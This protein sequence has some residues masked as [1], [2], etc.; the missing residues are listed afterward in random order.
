[1]E[2]SNPEWYKHLDISFCF[3]NGSADR[4]K[5]TLHVKVENNKLVHQHS[6]LRFC[7]IF[8]FLLTCFNY[9]LLRKVLRAY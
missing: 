7:G 2:D 1:M 8:V 3:E 9:Q 5:Q 4:S 6:L